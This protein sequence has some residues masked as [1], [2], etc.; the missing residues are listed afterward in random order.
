M[1]YAKRK[2]EELEL[3]SMVVAVQAAAGSMEGSNTGRP[4]LQLQP[5]KGGQEQRKGL[6]HKGASCCTKPGDRRKGRGSRGGGMGGQGWA[7]WRKEP[8]A[9][10]FQH[11]LITTLDVYHL[12]AGCYLACAL[13]V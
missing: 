1:G 12:G 10:N 11:E 5:R 3:T 13:A 7:E 2:R 6:R 4:Q 8:A 9:A